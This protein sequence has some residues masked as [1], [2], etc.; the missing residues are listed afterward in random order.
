MLF[1]KRNG[2]IYLFIFVVFLLFFMLFILMYHQQ[3]GIQIQLPFRLIFCRQ[4]RMYLIY[5]QERCG[6]YGQGI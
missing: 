3:Q 1:L 5:I 4:R 2:Y 6:L